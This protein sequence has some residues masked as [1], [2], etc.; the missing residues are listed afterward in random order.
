MS[1]P[2]TI[3]L[4]SGYRRVAWPG[5]LGDISAVLGVPDEPLGRVLLV[6][7]FTGS[8]EDYFAI[9]PDLLR[10][11]WS[12]AAVD[13]PGMFESAGSEDPADFTLQRLVADVAAMVHHFS[14]EPVH[15]VGHSA[16]GLI[17]R[18]VAVQQPNALASLTLYDSGCGSVVEDAR[19]NTEL[20]RAMLATTGPAEVH[21]IK[22]ALDEAAGRPK[23]PVEIAKFLAE[24]WQRTTAGHLLGMADLTLNAPDLVEELASLSSSGRLPVMA[25]YGEHDHNTWTQADFSALGSSAASRTVVI[26]D[27]EHSPAVENPAAT[28]EALDGFWRWTL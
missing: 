6:P 15:L 22:L 16:G 4:P 2:V 1:V 25:M 11:G 24:R 9:L 20:L 26:P 5:R 12:V 19:A 7:G 8:K 13:L 17:A 14:N 3:D 27:A 21:R 10:R 23:P 18:Q 28:V